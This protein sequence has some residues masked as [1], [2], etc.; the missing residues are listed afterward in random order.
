MAEK[1]EKKKR[2]TEEKRLEQ[3]LV[4]RARNNAAKSTIKTAVKKAKAA[5]ET[6]SEKT[7][8]LVRIAVKTIDKVAS[9]GIIHK[10]K[11]ARRKS[12]LMK[13]ANSANA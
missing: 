8:E 4:R 6:K 5:I 13:A 9:K 2:P 3:S 11:A 7:D 10:N 1:T 12:R